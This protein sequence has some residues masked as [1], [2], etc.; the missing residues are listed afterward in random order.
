MKIRATLGTV[1]ALS[2]AGIVGWQVYERLQQIGIEGPRRENVMR[3]IPI[4][5]EPVTR[6]PIERLRS[7]TG[8]LDA[9][10]E[11]VV[12][13]K[14]S[15][16]VEEITV[17]LSDTVTRGQVV[18]RMDNGEYVQALTQ[19]EADLAVAR[20]NL[21]EAESLMQISERELARIE[22]LRQRGVSSES[23]RDAAKANEL[24]RA[25]HVE[26]TRAQVTRARAAVE[27]AR[28]RLGYSEVTAG[29]RGGS[30]SR[31]VAERYV[32]E[33]DTVAAN[34]PLLRIVE[35]DPIVA[36]FYVTERDYGLLAV[37]QAVTLRTDAYP[38]ETFAGE[39]ARISPVFRENAR[40]ARV[41]MR[42]DNPDIRLKPGMFVR[43]SVRLERVADAVIV[44]ERALTV[45]DGR[46]GVFT[47][48][49]D[50]AT[51]IWRPVETGIREGDRVEVKGAALDGL[52]VTLG[53]QLLSDGAEVSVEP[54][55][56]G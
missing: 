28:I 9:F 55:G 51:V 54:G 21:A 11:F 24:A 56:A 40:Q 43:A 12:A 7:F 33:G 53:Q 42:A 16:R 18:A 13:P 37:G 39:I 29:W 6:G 22:T 5:A 2:V 26:V 8:T 3:K 10:A 27:T 48:A 14:V 36:V 15:G 1:V 4:E 32:D 52:V 30:D 34:A 44:P 46:E 35:L 45:R 20:A 50:G 49:A 47:V 17:D 38:G 41:E 23:E 31:V 19:A 25:A